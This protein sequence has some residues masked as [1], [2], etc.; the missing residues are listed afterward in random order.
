M[1]YRPS[2]RASPI[3]PAA[4]ARVRTGTGPSLTAMPPNSAL[5]TSTV[6]AP[7]SAARSAATAPAGPAPIT[8][9]LISG[10]RADAA[11]AWVETRCALR[12]ALAKAARAGRV[13][14]FPIGP[15]QVDSTLR[16]VAEAHEERRG[17]VGIGFGPSRQQRLVGRGCTFR[18]ARSFA[19]TACGQDLRVDRAIF[20]IVGDFEQRLDERRGDVQL[21]AGERHLGA[22]ASSRNVRRQNR[23]ELGEDRF[24]TIKIAVAHSA[25]APFEEQLAHGMGDMPSSASS[26]AA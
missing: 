13:A 18:F 12:S 7:R 23:V 8:R 10:R 26:A 16:P 20:R 25:H 3:N 11:S 9:R 17:M 1:P 5:D 14:E 4:C 15:G 24:R 2:C 22:M 6:L 19:V 21:S